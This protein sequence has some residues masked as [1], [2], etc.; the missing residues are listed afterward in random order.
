MRAEDEAPLTLWLADSQP[1]WRGQAAAALTSAG[2]AIRQFDHA[3]SMLTAAR[4]GAERPL[5][6]ALSVLGARQ[7]EVAMLAAL[8]RAIGPVLALVWTPTFAQMRGLFR[9]GAVDVARRP[10]NPVALVPL[11]EATRQAL[12]RRDLGPRRWHGAP[13]A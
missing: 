11:V 10:G 7:G 12:A 5:L 6:L 3:S 2:Y 1:A 9:E 4:G 8:T 13:L